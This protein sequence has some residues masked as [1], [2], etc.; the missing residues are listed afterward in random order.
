MTDAMTVTDARMSL[1]AG[2]PAGL[3]LAVAAGSAVVR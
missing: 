1:P 3:L 2:V